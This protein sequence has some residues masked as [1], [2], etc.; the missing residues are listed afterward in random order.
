MSPPDAQRI[1]VL[2]A[3]TMGHGIAQVAAQAGFDVT[4]QD[5]DRDALA[6]GVARMGANL[7]K[8]VSR[9]KLAREEA[10]A[11]RSRVRPEADLAVAVSGADLV[12]EAVPEDLELKRELFARVSEAAPEGAVLASNTSS[13]S[14]SRIAQAA[15]NPERVLGM[16]FFNPPY[17]LKLLELVRAGATSEAA[18]ETARAAG[19]RMEREIIVVSDSPGFATSRLGLVLGLEAMRMLEEGVASAEDI[20]RAMVHGYRHPMG[21]LRLSDL[22]GLDVRLA[23]ARYLSRELGDARFQ[24]PAVLERLVEEGKL[25]RKTGEGFFRWED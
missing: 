5:L 10:D 11:A 13:L 19:E 12:I 24:P 21:P 22:V 15:R 2:G 6:R 20:D 4:L 8:G 23:I 25:G 3:G 1:A 18:V 14:V 9:G 17:A 7:E 16:H